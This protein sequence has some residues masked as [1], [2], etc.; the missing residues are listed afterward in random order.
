MQALKQIN[1]NRIKEYKILYKFIFNEGN[2]KN[3]NDEEFILIQMACARIGSMILI[4]HKHNHRHNIHRY[5]NP[6]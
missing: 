1:V 5:H 2:E 6:L 3:K 4:Y